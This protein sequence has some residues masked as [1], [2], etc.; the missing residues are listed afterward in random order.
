[1]YRQ[2]LGERMAFRSADGRPIR[3]ARD[4]ETFEGSPAFTVEKR[5]GPPAI[6]A[7]RPG[8]EA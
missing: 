4:G 5:P 2:E 6:Y 7:P 8:D 1:V 3:L